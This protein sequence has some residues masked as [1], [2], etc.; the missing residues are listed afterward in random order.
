MSY[1]LWGYRG[2]LTLI[3]LRSER[4]N[5]FAPAPAKTRCTSVKFSRNWEKNLYHIFHFPQFCTLVARATMLV[6]SATILVAAPSPVIK[7]LPV[8][9]ST[10]L[11]HNKCK[12]TQEMLAK[13]RVSIIRNYDANCLLSITWLLGQLA[14][15][16]WGA[17][18]NEMFSHCSN[19]NKFIVKDKRKNNERGN[20]PTV[21]FYTLNC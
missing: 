9:G 6:T 13:S 15:S 3:T 16:D 8:A 7:L 5:P 1:F 12:R 18:R 4:V 17:T 10:K 21:R 20:Q 11:G 2:I 19:R 14:V